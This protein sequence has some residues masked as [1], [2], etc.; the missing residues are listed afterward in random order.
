MAKDKAV[1]KEEGTKRDNNE[2][3]KQV[4]SAIVEILRVVEERARAE[5]E[6]EYVT[7]E[8]ERGQA[9]AKDAILIRNEY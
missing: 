9:K 2:E 7:I 1:G 4:C 8:G 3:N 5:E 6:V